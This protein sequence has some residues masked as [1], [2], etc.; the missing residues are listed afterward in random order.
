MQHFQFFT[1]D[2]KLAFMYLW[3]MLCFGDII[4]NYTTHCQCTALGAFKVMFS[5]LN[6]LLMFVVCYTISD[7]M[8][9]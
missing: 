1:G 7:S 4:N 6:N 8:I 2:K 5:N 9:Q 3:F